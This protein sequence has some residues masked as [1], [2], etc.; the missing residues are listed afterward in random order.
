[1]EF[2]H[3]LRRFCLV[4]AGV[5]AGIISVCA[6]V[7]PGIQ[8]GIMPAEARAADTRAIPIT[9]PRDAGDI[10]YVD[11]GSSGLW[12][13]DNDGWHLL[14]PEDPTSLVRAGPA[15]V[16]GFGSLGLWGYDSVDWVS[17]GSDPGNGTKTIVAAVEGMVVDYGT[18]G[19]WYWDGSAWS[20][21]GGGMT[22]HMVGINGR[23][24]VDYGSEWGLWQWDGSAW[25]QLSPLDA[26]NGGN[27]MTGF[28]SGFVV[29]LG[30][31]G[32][33][34]YNWIDW[35]YV[36]PGYA[37]WMTRYNGRLAVD[38][39]T[40]GLWEFDSTEWSLLN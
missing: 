15:F 26:Y 6:P 9:C 4:A 37:E 29:D 2:S 1:M 35:T 13:I 19:L 28:M 5:V 12:Y 7:K 39:G 18:S 20:Y 16:A 31:W 38:Y 23:L 34:H 27:T 10:M 36:G 33:W 40:A 32:L 11:F 30:A 3:D 24:I 8:A 17:L 25:E 21:I 22:E 14:T